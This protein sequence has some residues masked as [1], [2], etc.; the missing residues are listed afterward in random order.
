MEM[1]P[2]SR[3]SEGTWVPYTEDTERSL[4]DDFKRLWATNFLDNLWIETLDD[5][6]PNG[7]MGKHVIYHMEERPRVKIVDYTGSSK[8]E[9]TKIDE[10]MKELGI[11]LRLD[12]FLD[13]G[14]VR[15]VEGVVRGLMAEKGFTNAEVTHKVTPVAGGPKLVNV[16]FNV[17]E[18][19]KI[20]IRK[21]EFVGNQAVSDGRL[22]RKL[23]ENKPKGLLSFITGGGTY[24]EA[25]FEAD[26]DKVVGQILRQLDMV[27][28][29]SAWSDPRQVH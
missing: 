21:V 17:S 15:R 22:Q 12:S 4:Q 14:V 27:T 18:G 11:Q 1:T 28:R 13:E 23:K 20:R 2:L 24:K 9:R 6:F 25:E 7:V 8:V 19:P 16:T 3:P 29:L 5:P 10:K 26:A